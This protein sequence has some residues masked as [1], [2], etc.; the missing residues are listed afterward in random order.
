M[1]SPLGLSIIAA[2]LLVLVVLAFIFPAQM[3]SPGGLT[4]AHAEIGQDCMACHVPLRGVAA[5]RCVTCHRVADIG[6]RT[7]KGLPLARPNLK[8]TFHQD[9]T[10]QNC[11][12]CH[13]EHHGPLFSA[14]D[15]KAFDHAQLTPARRGQCATCHAA[16]VDIIHPKGVGNC[17]QCHT[18]A[19]W[20]PA[21]FNHDRLFRLQGEHNV[22]CVTCH[23]LNTTSR[24]TCYGCHEHQPA[25]LRAR[26][27]EE[28][29]RNIDNC[30]ACHRGGE[31]SEHGERGGRGEREE[32]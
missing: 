16:P 21:T 29:I 32:D 1:K 5:E 8:T 20:K 7:T 26:H 6:L 28:G 24:F 15:R 23:T 25:D 14:L 30:V 27:L 31:D 12:A 10:Q 2:N 13:S 11:V 9:L 18:N 3:V 22:P 17:A 19:A 4:P